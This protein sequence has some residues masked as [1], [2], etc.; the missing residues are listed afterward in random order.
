MLRLSETRFKL[1]LGASGTIVWDFNPMTNRIYLSVNGTAFTGFEESDFPHTLD[2]CDNFIHPAD[3]P[4]HHK[5]ISEF[6][7]GRT[8]EFIYQ[9]RLLCKNGTYKWGITH[10]KAIEIDEIGNPIKVAGIIYDT[11]KQKEYEQLIYKAKEAADVSNQTTQKLLSLIAH[12][13]NTPLGLLTMSTDILSRYKDQINSSTAEKHLGQIHC[14]SR[15]LSRLVKSVISFSSCKNNSDKSTEEI[16]IINYIQEIICNVS[17]LW[18]RKLEYIVKSLPPQ[19]K[20]RINE[21]SFR[22]TL[23]NLISNAF[24]YTYDDTGNVTLTV[25]CNDDYMIVVVTDNGT[26]IPKAETARIFEAF[27][28][29]SNA[30]YCSGIGLGLSIVLDSL[31]K[32]NGT[33]K[34]KSKENVGSMFRV[35][36]PFEGISK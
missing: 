18:N 13:F 28:R 32:L 35:K 12:E 2:E 24:K 34:F 5:K 8:E 1:A 30:R 23:T 16:N 26:G 27:Y 31:H 21:Q 3:L 14:A 9:Y 19:C 36:I 15:E 22:Y 4:N 25:R 11:T 17:G 33:I 10:G 7:Q 20:I 29:G 6:L